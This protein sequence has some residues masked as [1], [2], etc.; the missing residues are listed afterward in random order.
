MHV[1]ATG[2][3]PKRLEDMQDAPAF[4]DPYTGQP[5]EYTTSQS[6]EGTVVTLKSA[7]PQSY[8]PLQALKVQFAQQLERQQ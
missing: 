2:K 4:P 6:P 1:D 3:L 5:F 8:P 7:G